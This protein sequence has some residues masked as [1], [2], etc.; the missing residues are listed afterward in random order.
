M[1]VARTDE[2]SVPHVGVSVERNYGL[3][4]PTIVFTSTEGVMYWR[5][6]VRL[7]RE[8]DAL[9]YGKRVVRELQSAKLDWSK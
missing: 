3:Y 7:N 9:A 6:R 4:V 5:L 2:N 1:N 8:R